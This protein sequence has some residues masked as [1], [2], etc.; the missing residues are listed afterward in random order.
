MPSS[1]SQRIAAA[2]KSVPS[3]AVGGA[4]AAMATQDTSA[5]V[6]CAWCA[7]CAVCCV[8]RM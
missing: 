8:I 3:S 6:C 1:I 2:R 4:L 7:W 5:A